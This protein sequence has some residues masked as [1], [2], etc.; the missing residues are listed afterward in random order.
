MRRSSYLG[1]STAARPPAVLPGRVL[2]STGHST[3]HRRRC[4]PSRRRRSSWSRWRPPD[5]S[6]PTRCSTDLRTKSVA[7][8]G[9]WWRDDVMT[10]W[11]DDVMTW[12]RDDVMTWWRDDAMTRW[13]DDVTTWWHDNV[14]TQWH[15]DAMTWWRDDV[16]TWWRDDMMT[17]TRPLFT[18]PLQ[19]RPART[20]VWDGPTRDNTQITLFCFDI[21]AVS[22]F[23]SQ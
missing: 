3:G 6:S 22:R 19:C 17:P 20:S 18:H 15:N 13:R 7:S 12:W 11:R 10:W 23:N 2:C 16:I 14:V 9:T 21:A 5:P 8:S 4:A 1:P